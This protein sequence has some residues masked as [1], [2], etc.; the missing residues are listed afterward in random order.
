[1]HGGGRKAEE[2][3]VSTRG[4]HKREFADLCKCSRILVGIWSPCNSVSAIGN[5]VKTIVLAFPDLKYRTVQ[6]ADKAPGSL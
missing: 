6:Y 4:S 2:L 3:E 1:M 5:K